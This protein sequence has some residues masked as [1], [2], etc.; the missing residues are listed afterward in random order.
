MANYAGIHSAQQ[1]M[2]LFDLEGKGYLTISQLRNFKRFLIQTRVTVPDLP[3]AETDR[4]VPSLSNT[5]TRSIITCS[6]VSF[7]AFPLAASYYCNNL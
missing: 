4:S 7:A 5:H 6:I 1:V 3:S 2:R